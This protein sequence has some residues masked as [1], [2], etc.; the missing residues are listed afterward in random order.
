MGPFQHLGP[1]SGDDRNTSDSKK[2][3][4]ISNEQKSSDVEKVEPK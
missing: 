4:E 1:K 2:D 3:V